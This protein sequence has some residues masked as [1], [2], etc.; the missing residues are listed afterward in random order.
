MRRPDR[1]EVERVEH[2]IFTASRY[3]PAK[4]MSLDWL[5]VVLC[6][7]V[8]SFKF[9]LTIFLTKNAPLLVLYGNNGHKW[10]DK[11]SLQEKEQT[12]ATYQSS[13]PSIHLWSILRLEHV[14]RP[15]K[16]PTKK[17]KN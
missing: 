5:V 4:W 1:P 12:A 6:N 15:M 7:Q 8:T 11:Y 3:P 10:I 17:K 9:S 14:S 13:K 16:S 2:G